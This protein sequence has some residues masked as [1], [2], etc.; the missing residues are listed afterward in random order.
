[1]FKGLLFV[2][3]NNLI[4]SH[5]VIYLSNELTLIKIL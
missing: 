3:T 5:V 1:M 2:D 4:E